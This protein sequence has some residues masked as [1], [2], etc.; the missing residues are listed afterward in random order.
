M[1]CKRAIS[2]IIM[3]GCLALPLPQ[4]THGQEQQPDE[5][6]IPKSMTFML[7]LLSPIGTANNKKGDNFSCK[8]LKPD[9]YAGAIVSGYIKKLKRSGKASGKSEI[10]LAFDTILFKDRVGGF[11]AQV[12]EIYEV[13]AAGN[14]GRADNE[15]VVRAKSTVKIDVAKAATGALIGAIIGGVIAGGQG[16]AIGAAIGAG[17]AVTT[18]L[19]TRGPDLEF[20]QGTQ[21]TVLTNTPAKR[22]KGRKPSRQETP[23]ASQ[24][25]IAANA[26][27]TQA[28]EATQTRQETVSVPTTASATPPSTAPAP[29][30]VAPASTVLAAAQPVR[31]PAPRAPSPRVQS[32]AANKIFS[33]S[34]PANWRESSNSNPV[35]LAP[36]GGYVLYQEQLVLTHGVRVG[37]LLQQS[38]GIQEASGQLISSLL[39]DRPYLRQQNDPRRTMI[40]RRDALAFKLMGASSLTQSN[41][42]VTVYTAM[43]RD[44]NLFYI[45]AI[46][47]QDQLLNYESAFQSIVQSVQI[48]D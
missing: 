39:Q 12:T 16:A 27:V 11:N 24:P 34:Y 18:T 47:P 31:P 25:E 28:A 32:Y 44:G 9:E 37:I 26:T 41:E 19:A 20:K 6:T 29:V 1:R 33:L 2:L 35:T 38:P 42:V 4:T 46:V 45:I 40:A 5:I 10:D 13:V 22:Q 43:L 23:I 15:G 7:E 36:S 30:P 48:N 14:G 3:I 17:L 8:V 21:F